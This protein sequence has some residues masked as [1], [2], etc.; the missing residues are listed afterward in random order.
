MPIHPSKWVC[1][2][3]LLKSACGNLIDDFPKYCSGSKA[4]VSVSRQ[5]SSITSPVYHLA[6]DLALAYLY[7]V[8]FQGPATAMIQAIRK[9][10]Y[11]QPYDSI[12]FAKYRNDTCQE[13]MYT[14]VHPLAKMANKVAV[15]YESVPVLFLHKKALDQIYQLIVYEEENTSFQCI[16][17]ISKSLQMICRFIIDGPDSEAFR[18]HVAKIDDFLWMSNEGMTSAS[19]NGTQMWDLAF[20]VQAVVDGGLAYEKANRESCMRAL[21]WLDKA[22]IR[23]NPKWYKEAYRHVSRGAWSFSTPVSTP[24]QGYTVSD[25]DIIIDGSA[26]ACYC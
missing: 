12:D 3:F 26:T 13:D 4:E 9:E 1:P 15:A 19:T 23:E 10:I 14:P 24:E 20:V 11:N 16:A 21:D 17:P 18:Q 5:A 8:K 2:K 25:D 6:L 7:G 22:Q